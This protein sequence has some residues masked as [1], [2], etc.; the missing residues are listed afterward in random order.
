MRPAF[1]LLGV[2]LLVGCG[3]ASTPTTPSQTPAPVNPPSVTQVWE[4]T[5]AT[6]A[7]R[8]YAFT[9]GLNGTV[10]ITLEGLTGPGVDENTRVSLGTGYPAGTGCIVQSAVDA[11]PSAEPQV[12]TTT[13]PGVYCVQLSD[14]GSLTAPTNFRLVIAH[15]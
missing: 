4:G 14:T 7:T 12:S 10:N 11:A 15:P 8:F 5:L 2:V 9:V 6:G 3:S 13:A 1:S